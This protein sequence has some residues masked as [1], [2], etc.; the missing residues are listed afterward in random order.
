LAAELVAAASNSAANEILV[1]GHSLGAVLAVD[2][3]DRALK[4]DPALGWNK[5]P[6][7]S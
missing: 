7:H 1:K 2:L 3:L 5:V 4:L 6:L